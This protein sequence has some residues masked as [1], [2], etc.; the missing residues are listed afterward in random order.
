MQPARS[1]RARAIEE[2]EQIESEERQDGDG[3]DD[4]HGGSVA[5][6]RP[7]GPLLGASRVYV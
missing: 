5:P 3:S 4:E 7:P 2:I 1:T 6:F